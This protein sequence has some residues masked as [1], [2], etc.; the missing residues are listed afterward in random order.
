MVSHLF[1]LC[2]YSVIEMSKGFKL[3][4]FHKLGSLIDKIK[5]L[6]LNL[7]YGINFGSFMY[8][9]LNL[10]SG[11]ITL[12]HERKVVFD[13]FFFPSLWFVYLPCVFHLIKNG[14]EWEDFEWKGRQTIC[15]YISI[16]GG[17][18][19][20]VVNGSC[21]SNSKEGNY[22]KRTCLTSKEFGMMLLMKISRI[23][24]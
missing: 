8:F 24:T 4:W 17:R 23:P 2:Y 1:M 15:F 13:F 14:R 18:G 6:R 3:K 12:T 21:N 16:M 11:K 20:K 19:L 5:N 22:T 9:Y 10:F 7:K